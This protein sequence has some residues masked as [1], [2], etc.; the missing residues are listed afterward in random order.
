MGKETRKYNQRQIMHSK[1]LFKSFSLFMLL[2]AAALM[3]AA[4]AAAVNEIGSPTV[5]A[6]LTSQSPDPLEP[7]KIAELKFSIRNR[8]KVTAIDVAVQL[9]ADEPF[10]IVG[11]NTEEIGSL[12]GGQTTGESTTVTFKIQAKSSTVEGDHTV[13]LKIRYNGIWTETGDFTVSVR[14]HDAVLNVIDYSI[15]PEEVSPGQPVKVSLSLKN[16][17]D[18]YLRDVSVRLALDK[19]GFVPYKSPDYKVLKQ[20]DAYNTAVVEFDII[21]DKSLESKVHSIPVEISYLDNFGSR[22]VRNSSLGLIVKDELNYIL[23]IDQT[24]V[25]SEK[26]TGSVVFSFYNTGTS[27]INF[28][29]LEMLESEDYEILSPQLVYLGNVESDDFESGEFKVYLRK[30]KREIEF[31]LRIKY[32]DNYNKEYTKLV[33][34]PLKIYSE[35]DAVKYNLKAAESKASQILYG[36]IGVLVL[37]FWLSMLIDCYRSKLPREKKYA[38]LAIIVLS[39]VFGAVAYYFIARGKNV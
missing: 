4:M 32:K 10:S 17:A 37:A 21:S 31:K 12:A 35:K 34:L 18:S 11:K 7:E 30:V 9:I 38:W 27:D 20:V 22:Y 24:E 33:V 36:M 23:N 8:G 3:F 19:S 1:L 2:I 14:T 15:E 25:F 13:K 16:Y 28:A 5:E 6:T 29:T 26:D 39:A